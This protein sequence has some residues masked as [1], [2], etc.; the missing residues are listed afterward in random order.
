[1]PLEEIYTFRLL[2]MTTIFFL[3]ILIS[4]LI[5]KTNFLLQKEGPSI[6]IH[7]KKWTERNK[8]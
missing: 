3:A 2:P 1:M 4:I 5:H 6:P 7:I 8:I